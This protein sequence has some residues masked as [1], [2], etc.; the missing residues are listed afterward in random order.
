MKEPGQETRFLVQRQ[1]VAFSP[2][3]YSVPLEERRVLART[4]PGGR[5]LRV[6]RRWE[7]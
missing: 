4:E 7:E 1:E 3:I 5:E 2:E 6:L